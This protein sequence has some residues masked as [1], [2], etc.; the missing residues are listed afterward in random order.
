MRSRPNKFKIFI[1]NI[2]NISPEQLQRFILS[3]VMDFSSFLIILA[4]IIIESAFNFAL[5]HGADLPHIIMVGHKWYL[6]SLLIL[7]SLYHY[8]RFKYERRTNKR[9]VD[10]ILAKLFIGTDAVD[11]CAIDKSRNGIGIRSNM[12]L[13]KGVICKL[14]TPDYTT[15]VEIVWYNARSGRAGLLK[16][17][18]AMSLIMRLRHAC[19]QILER[20]QVAVAPSSRIGSTHYGVLQ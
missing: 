16:L 19:Y 12:P 20:I 3:V 13:H 1:N 8:I 2:L 6:S 10:P 14:S 9:L 15:H 4:I 5:Q 18:D 11:V 7:V 17:N